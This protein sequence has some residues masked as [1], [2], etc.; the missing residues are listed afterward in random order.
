MNKLKLIVALTK[1]ANEHGLDTEANMPDFIIGTFMYSS[2]ESLM[3][4][5]KANG[6]FF[7]LSAQE[8][9]AE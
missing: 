1:I 9:E 4:A 2:F 8:D 5:N 6:E 7:K 3:S